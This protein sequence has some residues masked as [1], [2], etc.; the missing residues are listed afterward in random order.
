MWEALISRSRIGL[1]VSILLVYLLVVMGAML[2]ASAAHEAETRSEA[3]VEFNG[4]HFVVG[5]DVID[6]EEGSESDEWSDQANATQGPD[7]DLPGE[8]YADEFEEVLINQMLTSAYSVVA[9]SG[10]L[11]ATFVYDHQSWLPWAVLEIVFLLAQLPPFI[12]MGYYVA[13][14]VYRILEVI[15]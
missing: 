4:T 6:V 2:G 11:V 5:D 10:D 12:F 7:Y 13:G 1:L 15:R 9:W 8:S 14:F 3:S